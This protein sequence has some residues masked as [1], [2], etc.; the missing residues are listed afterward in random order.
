LLNI[1]QDETLDIY[2]PKYPSRQGEGVMD[3]RKMKG[4]MIVALATLIVIYPWTLSWAR[5]D[6]IICDEH[7][8]ITG[9]VRISNHLQ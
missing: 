8:K 3:L 5:E 9:P 2:S 1:I 7:G 4:L 6:I